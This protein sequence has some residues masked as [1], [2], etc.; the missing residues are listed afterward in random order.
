MTA[1]T[2]VLRALL[3]GCRPARPVVWDPHPRG[4]D[5]VPGCA[6]GHPEPRR[7]RAFAGPAR[8]A[9][10]GPAAGRRARRRARPPL[11]APQ[12]VAVTL[13]DRRRAAVAYGD[14]APLV[15]RAGG[16]RP[17]TP[18]ARA[19]ASRAAAA[20]PWPRRRVADRGGRARA[21]PTPRPAWPPAAP[22]AVPS[23]GRPAASRLRRLAGEVSTR[24]RAPAAARVVATGG[25]FDLLHAGHVATLRGRPRASATAWSC[26][27]TPTPRCA[28]S[29]GR[30]G[31]SCP[32]ADRARVLEALACV[33]AVVVFDE[34][35]PGA[36]LDAAAPGRLGQGRRLRRGRPAGGWL[37][38]A[39]GAARSCSCRTWP[40][41]PPPRIA[42]ADRVVTT[43]QPMGRSTNDELG[44]VLVTGG[45][46]GLGA[47]VV[48]GRR[49]PAAR[50]RRARPGRRRRPTCDARGGRPRRLAA[51]PRRAVAR[52][53]ERV[54]RP[55][56]RRHR[57][58]APTPAAALATCRPR[59]G[60]GGRV[61]LLGTAAVVRAALPH[62]RARRGTV[63]TV[64]STLGLRAL[65]TPRPTAR[66]SSGSW[67]SPG[68]WR[69]S[70]PARSASRCWSPAACSTA[71]F[72]GR[73]EQYRPA[74]TPSSTTR[75]TSRRPCCSRCASRPGARSASW[76][77]P[78]RTEPSWP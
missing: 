13:G 58:R 2:R 29:R 33:D 44:T 8:P 16:R 15:V 3:A 47:A 62:L 7:G 63:V 75:P 64:A 9:A 73:T 77:S 24:R 59:L 43:W 74:R 56:R 54:G 11:A 76:W 61:N 70:W 78:R 12:A 30:A 37:L 39:A 67:A 71:F 32:S 26:C 51:P 10:T 36:V 49:R 66:R 55:R 52:L 68:R 4:A 45:A 25:C 6:A 46:A 72:D 60:A 1:P 22:A 31:R 18:A 41:G 57:R 19:T 17:A 35:T 34:D 48:A 38:A 23:A 42:A 20:P 65:R 5:P 50:R 53:V 27:S 28:G 69:R 40:G 21:S 14:G